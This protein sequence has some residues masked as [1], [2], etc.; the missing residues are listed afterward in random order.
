MQ[1]L[2][3]YAAACVLVLI[4]KSEVHEAGHR[5]GP[6]LST[7]DFTNLT[8]RQDLT[9]SGDRMRDSED[10]ITIADVSQE[11]GFS[12]EVGKKPILCE[13]RS[14][15]KYAG[16][17]TLAYREYTL[18]RSNPNSKLVCGLSCHV[19]IGPSWIQRQRIWQ[20]IILPK[21]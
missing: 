14:S 19:R 20:D 18:P 9:A 2:C 15:K 21:S 16:R 8:H 7:E 11:A 5:E 13:N 1:Q 3:I 6:E 12:A 17:W 4:D 10:S